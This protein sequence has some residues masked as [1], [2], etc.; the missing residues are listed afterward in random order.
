M[1]KMFTVILFLVAVSFAQN[2]QVTALKEL[3]VIDSIKAVAR[4]NMNIDNSGIIPV[5]TG[6]SAEGDRLM[7]QATKL[8]LEWSNKYP[9]YAKIMDNRYTNK[10]SNLMKGIGTVQILCGVAGLI[11]T[12][13]SANMPQE[14]TAD[15][16][17]VSSSKYSTSTTEK[18][19]GTYDPQ[20]NTIHTVTTILSSGLILSGSITVCF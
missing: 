5:K 8:E 18:K 2:D 7:A 13:V 20:W 3:N 11:T 16:P 17:V 14:Y 9:I 6:S 15:V 12:I 10:K 19:T 4:K 1:N